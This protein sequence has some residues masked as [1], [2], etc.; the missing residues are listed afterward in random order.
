VNPFPVLRR[1]RVGKNGVIYVFIEAGD[2][3]PAY[4]KSL[5]EAYTVQ[6]KGFAYFRRFIEE[7]LIDRVNDP[8]ELDEFQSNLF[9]EEYGLR[10]KIW[11]LLHR[12]DF[13][14]SFHLYCLRRG[15]Q[16]LIYLYTQL[17]KSKN[18]LKYLPL[19]KLQLWL[20]VRAAIEDGLSQ[21][22]FFW[23]PERP[24]FYLN[25]IDIEPAKEIILEKFI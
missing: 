23:S 21:K 5:L 22:D 10:D 13:P 14:S 25:E 3:M 17:G 6:T 7:I 19:G 18:G 2:D 20:R 8:P 9:W 15:D 1:L 12:E 11:S 16:T 4:E 24:G